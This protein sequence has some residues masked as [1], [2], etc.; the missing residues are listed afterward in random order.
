MT[1]SDRKARKDAAMA[2]VRTVE[3]ILRRWDP[4]GIEPGVFAP[5]D[6]YDGYAPHIV[7]MVKATTTLEELAAHLDHIATVTIDVGP[8]SVASQAHSRKFAG[9]IIEALRPSAG[10]S[11]GL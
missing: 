2:E 11:S 10:Q 4:I 3:A 6:E 9:E 1:V 7:S 8:S 5:P